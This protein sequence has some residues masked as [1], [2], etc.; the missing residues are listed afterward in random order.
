MDAEM[1]ECAFCTNSG[2]MSAEHIFPQWVR[3]L[4][5]GK[6]AAFY[7][8]GASNR[9]ERFETETIDWKAKVVCEK[10][11]TTW[12]SDIEGVHGKPVL[13]PFIVGE[14]G[15]PITQE[16][17]RSIAL[18]AFKTAVVANHADHK[19]QPFFSARLRH[20]FRVN[21]GI[22]GNVNIWICGIKHH[23]GDVRI[24]TVY[25]SGQL[26]TTNHWKMYVFTC[27]IGCLIMQVVAVEQFGR[28]RFLPHAR[29]KDIGIPITLPISPDC[30]WP[31]R[32]VLD[33]NVDFDGFANRWA[34]VDLQIIRGD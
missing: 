12:M 26:S 4:F 6:K 27:G 32:Y 18:Y 10:C 34:Q 20:E 7:I 29:Y 2:K 19:L 22:P 14:I 33:G 28:I 11:N 23:Q 17:A 25:Y 9:N 30:V 16:T 15:I 13:T 3:G 21:H 8:G 31:G 5:P 1:K 24:K